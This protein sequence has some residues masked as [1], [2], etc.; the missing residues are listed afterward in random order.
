VLEIG[1]GPVQ[2]LAREYARMFLLNE[3]YRCCVIRINPVKERSG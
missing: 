1:A 3:K 2:P